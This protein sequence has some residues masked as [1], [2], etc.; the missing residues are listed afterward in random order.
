MGEGW[1]LEY[2][3]HHPVVRGPGSPGWLTLQQPRRSHH[4]HALGQGV[5]YRCKRGLSTCCRILA[6]MGRK[7]SERSA[8]RSHP[9]LVIIAAKY[10]VERRLKGNGKADL[11]KEEAKL[12]RLRLSPSSL[13]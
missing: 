7:G 12:K 13:S 8:C 11:R 3:R 9:E 2:D 1:P 5:R 10:N 6:D 4:S